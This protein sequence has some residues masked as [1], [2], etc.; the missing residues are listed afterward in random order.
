M[1]VGHVITHSAGMISVE[2]ESCSAAAK[3]LDF[4]KN[5][6]TYKRLESLV[7]PENARQVVLECNIQANEENPRA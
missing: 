1:N 5:T 7:G 4:L 6:A 3:S 2:T